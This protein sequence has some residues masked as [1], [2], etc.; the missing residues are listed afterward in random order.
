MVD[1]KILSYGGIYLAKLDPSKGKEISKIR[2]IVLLTAEVIL[3]VSPSIVFICP[4]SSHSYPEFKQLHVELPPRDNLMVT[5]Y[6][7]VEHCRSITVERLMHPRLGQL[8]EVEIS[9]I[10]SRFTR[11]IGL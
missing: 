8:L 5:S 3:N 4:L 2:P 10:L 6:A 7:L 1:R 9:T 11:I